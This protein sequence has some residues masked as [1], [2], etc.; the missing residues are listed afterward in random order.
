MIAFIARQQASSL[1]ESSG[2]RLLRVAWDC[3]RDGGLD[4]WQLA[5]EIDLLRSSGLANTDLRWLVSRA[6]VDHRTELTRPM[7]RTR[8]FR[9]STS[10]S[11][12]LTPRDCFVLTESGYEFA[13]GEGRGWSAIRKTSGNGTERVPHW[14]AMLH[15]VRFGCTLV[16]RFKRPPSAQGL[17]LS[18][19]Q[20][21]GWPPAIDDPLP[22]QHN[23]DPKRRLHY[24]IR[25]LNRGRRRRAPGR[26]S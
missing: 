7:D 23:Q 19:F 3:A 10:H 21:E 12:A 4:L 24:T 9:K 25:N 22:A 11:F 6:L 1:V 26:G 18:A 5:V 8:R 2:L 13:A 14:D 17:I 20:E 15:E 16:K